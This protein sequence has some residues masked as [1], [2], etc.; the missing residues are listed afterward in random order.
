[1]KAF[2]DQEFLLSNETASRL[3]HEVAEPMEIYDY[4]NHLDARE[5][6]E[7]RSFE[8]LTQVW[9]GGD[10]YK[11]RV[12]RAYGISEELITGDGAPYDKYY[13][14]VE[15]LEHAMGN[16]LYHWSHMELQRY[17]G[18]FE[19]LTTRNARQVWEK[20]NAKLKEPGFSVRGLLK[21]QK[22]KALCT[23]NDPV[24]D[25][26]WHRLL[27]Q[28]NSEIEV[29][30]T[31][32]PDGAM[33]VDGG[34]YT[35]YLEKL[36]ELTGIS[37]ESPAELV[38]A[39]EKRLEYFVKEA[40]CKITDHSLE[41]RIFVPCTEEEAEAIFA[42]RGQEILTQEEI[43]KY[44]SFLL[45]KLGALY[46]KYHLVMQLHMGAM[47]N[48]S[49]R[50]YAKIGPNTGYDSM[51]DM[52]YARELRLLLNTLD[53]ADQLPRTILYCL[54]PKDFDMLAA[55][56]GNYQEAPYRGKVQLGPAWWFC[57]NRDGM[58]KQ[59]KVL[60]N[61]GLLFGFVGMLTDSRSFLSFPRHEYFR[62]ILC[63]L[64][65]V[66]VENGEIPCDWDMLKE[67]IES[68]CYNNISTYLLQIQ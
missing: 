4:H 7:D 51:D 46:H 33:D 14:W 30:P 49:D 9:L 52:N 41:E 45:E 50:M 44:R 57:D 12:M 53:A 59:M 23:T 1:M 61:Q 29:Y 43:M 67:F 58:E 31:F 37:I 36:G 17:F 55:A 66:W 68:I 42:R 25:L 28:E 40:G 15:T 62:R 22:V 54:N 34:T 11:W 2:M 64:I 56:A 6:Y 38:N 27:Q 26:K 48:N 60:A 32:R 18:I 19:P 35:S 10:H 13:A 21:Q 63:N 3:F 39:L 24:E 47:R 20:C 16:P 5:I 65:G 8:N